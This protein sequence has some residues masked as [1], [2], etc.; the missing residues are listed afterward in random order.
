M[1]YYGAIPTQITGNWPDYGGTD[2]RFWV[3][4]IDYVLGFRQT[5]DGVYQDVSSMVGYGGDFGWGQTAINSPPSSTQYMDY[6]DNPLRPNLRHWFGPILLV[7]FLQNYNMSVNTPGYFVM[8]AGD[9][10]EAPIYN[11]KQAFLAAVDTMQ[12]NHPNDSV[13]VVP[14]SS[15]RT[16]VGN[17]SNPVPGRFN[18][19]GSPLSANYNYAKAAL[20]FPFSTINPDGSANNTEITPYDPDPSTG[21]IP[22]ANFADTPRAEGGTCFSMGLMLAYNQFAS[23]APADGTLRNFVT[24][25]PITFPA[26]MAG[27]LGRKGAQK[28][29]IFETDG[30]PNTAAYA[31]LN[32]NGSYKYYSVRYNMNNPWGSEY[33]S[34][35][36]S[37]D[38]DPAVLNQVYS[39]VQQLATDHGTSRNPFRLYALGFGPVFQGPNSTSAMS[40]L[41]TMQYYAGT[42]SSPSTALPSNQVITGTGAQ[43]SA[44]MIAAFTSILQNGKQ[45][46]LIK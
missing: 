27:G 33:P 21:T 14:Y 43:M 40:T 2:Q 11:A 3:E 19:V 28:V 45:I 22:S 46:A 23:T 1:K 44:S 42:Q 35:Y 16:G 12:A 30:L 37:Y 25:S 17:Q 41:Q 24:S 7:D 4:F 34:S 5:S 8:Q 39:L 9:S 10:Y 18:S 32:N 29:V 36:G 15:P 26:G 6:R 38:N 13:T 20:V 31:S